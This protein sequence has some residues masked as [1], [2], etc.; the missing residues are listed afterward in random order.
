MRSAL[1]AAY[2]C[3]PEA[4]ATWLAAAQR[5]LSPADTDLIEV[6]LT[7]IYALD[8]LL[9]LLFQYDIVITPRKVETIHEG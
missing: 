1:R 3:V 2:Y 9:H 5:N 6:A 7:T 8:K 4:I